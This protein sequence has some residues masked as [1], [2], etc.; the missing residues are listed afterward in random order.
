MREALF[1]L[2][3][4]Q[5]NAILVHSSLSNLGFIPGGVGSVLQTLADWC[6]DATLAMPTHTYCYPDE[7]GDLEV[8][9]PQFTG[10]VVG[11]IS[12]AYWRLP[13]VCRS[14]HPTHSLAARG[15]LASALV[16]NHQRCNSPCGQGSPYARLVEWDAGVLMFGVTMNSYTLFHTAED[17]A[18]VPYLYEEK[19][20]ALQ[21]REPCGSTYAISTKRQDM[22]VTRRFAELDSWLEMRGLLERRRVGHGE[23][24]WIPHAAAVHAAL[25]KALAADPWLLVKRLG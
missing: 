3:V 20:Y 19:R 10:S 7:R 21:V 1:G 12:D 8:F 11:A 18:N 4:P 9:D 15:R 5:N 25:T 14:L 13:G 22:D 23:I 24:L 6:R 17:A 2:G 16:A